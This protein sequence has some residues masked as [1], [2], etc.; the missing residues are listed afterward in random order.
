[1]PPANTL[2][3]RDAIVGACA[4]YLIGKLRLKVISAKWGVS[5]SSI[6]WHVRKAGF[7]LRNKRRQNNHHSMPSEYQN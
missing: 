1:M 4:D 7:K 3:P 5:D 2:L 6:I